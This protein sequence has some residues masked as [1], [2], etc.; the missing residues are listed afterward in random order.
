MEHDFYKRLHF[1]GALSN[2]Y[3]HEM[4]H[5]ILYFL[6]IRAMLVDERGY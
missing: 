1:S 4:K 2:L 6:F 5:Y 3:L